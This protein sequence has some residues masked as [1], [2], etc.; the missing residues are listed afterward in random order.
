MLRHGLFFAFLFHFSRNFKSFLHLTRFGDP[1]NLGAAHD[2]AHV[3]CQGMGPARRP[4][5]IYVKLRSALVS[6]EPSDQ[7][8]I[9]AACVF[10][11]F[12]VLLVDLFLKLACRSFSLIL[13]WSFASALQGALLVDSAPPWPG[14]LSIPC[15]INWQSKQFSTL[16][17]NSPHTACSVFIF[18]ICSLLQANTKRYSWL[19]ESWIAASTWFKLQ[20]AMIGNVIESSSRSSL[21]GKVQESLS[22]KAHRHFCKT[23]TACE[24]RFETLFPMWHL[25]ADEASSHWSPGR[26]R[27]RR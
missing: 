19:L 6:C 24:R 11:L 2:S 1:S 5:I 9:L 7:N 14:A 27:Y 15:V 22:H 26:G 3:L 21:E 23:W 18:S 20:K 13:F 17:E 8:C 12:L 16:K 10:D 25:T 4:H